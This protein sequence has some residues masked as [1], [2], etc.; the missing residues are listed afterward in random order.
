[1]DLNQA[2]PDSNLPTDNSTDTK[3][4]IETD[5]KLDNKMMGLNN[6]EIRNFNHQFGLIKLHK[7]EMIEGSDSMREET[8]ATNESS[9]TSKLRMS[10]NQAKIADQEVLAKIPNREVLKVEEKIST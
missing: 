5:A 7:C 3:H 10:I 2:T 4:K 8:I 1:M 6:T 9:T